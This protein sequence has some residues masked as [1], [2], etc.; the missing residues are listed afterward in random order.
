MFFCRQFGFQRRCWKR[1]R[2]LIVFFWI[3]A[4]KCV[5]CRR[6]DNFQNVHV[7]L[8]FWFW[9]LSSS[10]FQAESAV[11][12]LNLSCEYDDLWP[13]AYLSF[14]CILAPCL[15]LD[16]PFKEKVVLC[17][18]RLFNLKPAFSKRTRHTL[19]F[20]QDFIG[21]FFLSRTEIYCNLQ[22][23][24]TGVASINPRWCHYQTLEIDP[25]SRWGYS[26]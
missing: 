25:S 22:L 24:S 26:R 14:L 2:F 4:K 12:V 18:Y 23:C 20:S 3:E 16:F 21:L 10:P 13:N 9:T 19:A 7:V 1:K 17:F 15:F 6:L 11:N 5:V 8:G